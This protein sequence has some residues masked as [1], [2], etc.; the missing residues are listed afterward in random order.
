[1]STDEAF[2]ASTNLSPSWK[3]RLPQQW[4]DS[5]VSRR[6]MP[7]IMDPAMTAANTTHNTCLILLHEKIAYPDTRL[8]W[9]QLPSL[10]SADTCQSASYE[11]CATIRK[12]L[13]QRV[14]D[15][16]LSPQLGLCAFVSARSLLGGF[17][18]AVSANILN[19][20]CSHLE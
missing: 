4:V 6:I 20:R 17:F 13:K 7:G 15:Y 8:S 3:S 2:D 1:M 11:V 14:S 10:Y 5:G 19:L 12:F 18:A 9:L 16:P